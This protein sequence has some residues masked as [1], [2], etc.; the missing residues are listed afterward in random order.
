MPC[1]PWKPGTDEQTNE[2]DD[3]TKS[4]QC[5]EV[6][7]RAALT[8]ENDA[9]NDAKTLFDDDGEAAELRTLR[10]KVSVT[11]YA[12]AAIEGR[13]AMNGA[14]AEFNAALGA[15]ADAFPLILLAGAEPE[16]RA[17]TD[18]DTATRPR[19][20]LD[21]LLA[22]TMA[23]YLGISFQSVDP[24]IASYPVT[25]AGASGAQR[26]AHRSGNSNGLDCGRDGTETEP[27]RD[28]S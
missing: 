10:G 14:E 5:H 15:G 1:Y 6:E 18:T 19:P 22:E 26:G 4:I 25:T 12:Q 27:Q 7:Y 3:L 9:L 16:K 24:G 11:R 17:T 23:A 21:R 28:S 20:W 8:A 2:L 13:Q